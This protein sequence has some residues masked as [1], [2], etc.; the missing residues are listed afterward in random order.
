[1][2]P[3]LIAQWALVLLVVVACGCAAVAVIAQT[4]RSIRDAA[5]PHRTGRE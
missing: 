4:Y 2:N 1:M 3:W 5:R